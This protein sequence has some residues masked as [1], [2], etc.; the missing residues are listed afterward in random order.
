M[1]DDFSQVNFYH[2]PNLDLNI[3]FYFGIH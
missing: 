2:F 1:I 3:F